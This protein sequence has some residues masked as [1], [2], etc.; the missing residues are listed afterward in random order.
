MYSQARKIKMTK[1]ENQ[2]AKFIWQYRTLPEVEIWTFSLMSGI[3]KGLG[4]VRHSLNSFQA[5][6]NIV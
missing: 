4:I 5:M 1:M 2:V 6:L 3:A